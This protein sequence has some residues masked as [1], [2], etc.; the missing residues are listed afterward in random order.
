[1][2]YKIREAL[3][4]KGITSKQMASILGVSE[5]TFSGYVNGDHDPKSENLSRIAITC[6]VSTDFLLGITDDPNPKS[7]NTPE[8]AATSSEAKEEEIYQM[9]KKLVSDLHIDLS[10]LTDRQKLALEIISNIIA[11]NF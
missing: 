3:K 1:M 10:A 7:T 11:D 5:G 8:P 4:I 6:G 2:R 9:L